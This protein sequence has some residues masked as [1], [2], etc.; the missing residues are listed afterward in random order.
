MEQLNQLESKAS[1]EERFLGKDRKL[2]ICEMFQQLV[3]QFPGE[4]RAVQDTCQAS[5]V[6]S[7]Q[8]D[9]VIRRPSGLGT[10]HEGCTWTRKLAG[11][12]LGSP[13]SVE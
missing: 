10:Q 8:V 9:W 13:F 7:R 2:Q 1:G 3:L 4:E 12:Y 6:G 5:F 11:S